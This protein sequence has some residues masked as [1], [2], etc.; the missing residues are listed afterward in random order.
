MNGHGAPCLAHTECRRPC[1]YERDQAS[2][3]RY[4][5]FARYA[6][7]CEY[8]YHLTAAF[9]GQRSSPYLTINLTTV[10]E[11]Q[12]GTIHKIHNHL[13]DPFFL[14][15]E[16]SGVQCVVS[17]MGQPGPIKKPI[18]NETL[19]KPMKRIVIESP[20]D[21]PRRKIRPRRTTWRNGET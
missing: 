21:S 10:H 20:G 14:H 15:N 11:N 2:D 13:V 16:Q 6:L 12:K 1:V 3:R 17:L 7:R 9:P 8:V 18:L 5:Q 4:S 19:I